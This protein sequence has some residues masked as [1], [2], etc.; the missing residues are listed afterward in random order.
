MQT[1]GKQEQVK[2]DTIPLL[3]QAAVWRGRQAFWNNDTN[4]CIIANYNCYEKK[5]GSFKVYDKEPGLALQS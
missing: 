1:L 5:T 4:E 3:M 2:A